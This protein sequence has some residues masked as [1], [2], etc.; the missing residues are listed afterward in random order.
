MQESFLR[1]AEAADKA[2]LDTPTHF[3][4]RVMRNLVIDR[5]RGRARAERLFEQGAAPDTADSDPGPERAAIA[6]D[7]LRR[8]MAIINSMPERRREVFCLH[9]IDGLRYRQIARQLGIS[10]SAVEKHIRLAMAQ[11]SREMD[12]A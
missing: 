1:V 6:N 5:L 4:F 2:R 12:E 8:V 7:R 3:L 9:R 10:V 11:I